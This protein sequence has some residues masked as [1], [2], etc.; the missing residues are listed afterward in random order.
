MGDIQPEQEIDPHPVHETEQQLDDLE[1]GIR[2]HL[3]DVADD[4]IFL[5]HLEEKLNSF[6]LHRNGGALVVPLFAA[7]GDGDRVDDLPFQSD[8][9]HNDE[10]EARCVSASGPGAIQRKE[11]LFARVDDFSLVQPQVLFL[12]LDDYGRDH[13]FDLSVYLFGN[14]IHMRGLVLAVGHTDHRV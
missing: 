9:G 1:I 3:L 7:L 5:H 8:F 14:W 12:Q 6:G 13:L 11:E 10:A 2:A 4:F